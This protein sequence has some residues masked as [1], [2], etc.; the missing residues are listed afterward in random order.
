MKWNQATGEP[1]V[2][3]SHTGYELVRPVS[4]R[5]ALDPNR[6]QAGRFS[7]FAG[8]RRFAFNHHV[9]RVKAN[10]EQRSQ[11]REAGIAG[12]CDDPEPVVVGAVVHQRVQRLEERPR[13]R[14]PDRRGPRRRDRRARRAAGPAV[15][16]R[17]VRRRVRVRQRRCGPG[18]QELRRVRQGRPRRRPGRVPA[19]PGQAP[20]HALASGSDPSPSPARPHR[21]GSRRPSRSCCPRSGRS[22]S[23]AV[24]ARSPGCSPR[25]GS[26]STRRPCPF[27]KGRWWVSVNGVAATFH[28]QRRSS[29][30]AASQA[31]WARSR[32]QTPRR[33]RRHRRP[34]TSGVGGGERTRRAQT[35][36][37]R[38]NKALAR[39]KPG[40]GGRA[41]ARAR[42]TKVHARIAHLRRDLA[43]RISHWLTTNLTRL[44][45]E[46]LNVAGMGRL[47]TL[48]RAIADAGLGDLL[49][50]VAYKAAWYGCELHV[51]D[52]WYPSSKTC[53]NCGHVKT[54]LGLDERTYRCEQLRA[55][56]RP[57]P[58]RRGQ[59]GP[60]ARP[61]A[62][63]HL[64]TATG[65]RLTHVTGRTVKQTGRADRHPYTPTSVGPGPRIGTG[66]RSWHPRY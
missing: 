39:T 17:G 43:H 37:R 32:R 63:N 36:L 46:D 59:P 6:E 23:T 64:V 34:R 1:G 18:V 16:G 28:H 41:K 40:S 30:R 47:R 12:R 45:V 55:R 42:L 53:S 10:L 21:S 24:P 49:R 50:Q 61:P 58:E 27:S 19:V 5:F 13:R 29:G 8:A 7:M 38:A 14:Q 26:T 62:G 11:E 25:A 57:G 33:R 54:S 35:K 31:G 44:T 20:L 51:A 65:G 52:R 2:L 56:H 66:T 48:A 3:V 22:G 4:F 15:A 9:G 60:L